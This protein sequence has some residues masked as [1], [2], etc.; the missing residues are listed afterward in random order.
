MRLCLAQNVLGG[1]AMVSCRRGNGKGRVAE[2]WSESKQREEDLGAHDV[3]TRT[4]S[5]DPAHPS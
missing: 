1:G 2:E 3:A 5:A 4:T